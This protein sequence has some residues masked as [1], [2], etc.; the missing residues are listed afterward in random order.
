[1]RQRCAQQQPAAVD[2]RARRGD[3]D[4]QNEGDFLIGQLFQV[5]QHNR[6]AE[7]DG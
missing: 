4:A 3:F 2:P 6:G 7:G 5:V 1:M